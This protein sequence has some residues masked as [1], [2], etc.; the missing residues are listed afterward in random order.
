MRS[1]RYVAH[2]VANGDDRVITC[3]IGVAYD[4]RIMYLSLAG[5]IV[6]L[7]Q[8]L[9][10]RPRLPAVRADLSSWLS[11]VHYEQNRLF[12]AAADSPALWRLLEH[13]GILTFQRI[14]ID[15]SFCTFELAESLHSPV[16]LVNTNLAPPGLADL[17]RSGVLSFVDAH[18]IDESICSRCKTDYATCPCSKFIDDV[19]QEIT[20]GS[21]CG[22]CLEQP[23]GGG[24][25]RHRSGR[26]ISR[27]AVVAAW[28]KSKC[29]REVRML[30]RAIIS[31]QRTA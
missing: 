17:L 22:A 29:R 31:K 21:W 5:H 25:L 1:P 23:P 12:P 3:S 4:D 16:L 10:T 8:F 14:L 7:Q 2:W 18:W 24:P 19:G 9:Q 15:Q 11:A 27:A 20:K 6:D 26:R 13:T 28:S 30:Y